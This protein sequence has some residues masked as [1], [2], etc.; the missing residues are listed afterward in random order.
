MIGTLRELS[1]RCSFQQ[2]HLHVVFKNLHKLPNLQSLDL[3][4]AKFE[5]LDRVTRPSQEVEQRMKASKIRKLNLNLRNSPLLL[6]EN[7]QDVNQSLH[8]LAS[9]LPNLSSFGFLS[10]EINRGVVPSYELQSLLDKNKY[11]SKLVREDNEVA[12]SLWPLVFIHISRHRDC[13]CE[14]MT[15]EL[16]AFEHQRRL[17]ISFQVVRLVADRLG[18]SGEP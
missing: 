18:K 2:E 6:S 9:L 16:R 3:C 15:D 8:C 11:G 14:P 10:T 13:P 12:P 5:S 7:P 1:F 4:K 17:E